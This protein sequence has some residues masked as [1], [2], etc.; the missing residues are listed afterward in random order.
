MLFEIYK[1]CSLKLENYWIIEFHLCKAKFMDDADV[2][3]IAQVKR[4]NC[5]FLRG[6]LTETPRVKGM[7]W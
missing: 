4:Q 7:V 1:E 3:T 6:Q 5:D 2:I